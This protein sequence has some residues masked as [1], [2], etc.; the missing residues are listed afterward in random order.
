MS[1]NKKLAAIHIG[2]KKLGLDET[3][4]RAKLELVTGKRSAGDMSESELD[5][6][7]E[8]F[9]DDGFS[10]RRSNA[11]TSA[12]PSHA[13]MRAMWISL[14]HL[15]AV[16]DR[17]DAALDAFVKHQTGIEKAAWVPPEETYKV[18]EALKEMCGRAGFEIEDREKNREPHKVQLIHVL[19]DKINK[20][21]RAALA[22]DKNLSRMTPGEVDALAGELGHRL[23]DLKAASK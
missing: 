1:R 3:T 19:L 20:Y 8:S 9:R 13:F 16:A 23:R 5:M 12:N 18:I 11:S 4:Y 2:K 15:G 17:T 22:L 21:E 10:R 7:L 14:F 6:V